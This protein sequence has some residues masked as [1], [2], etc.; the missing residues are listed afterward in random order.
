[1]D[2]LV[3]CDPCID[4]EDPT[5]CTV[6]EVDNVAPGHIVLQLNCRDSTGTGGTIYQVETFSDIPARTTLMGGE[7]VWFRYF[8]WTGDGP[9]IPHFFSIKTEA[10]KLLM[11]GIDAFSARPRA[12]PGDW[13]DPIYIEVIDGLCPTEPFDC[14]DLER[15]SLQVTYGDYVKYV[16]D[17]TTETIGYTEPYHIQVDNAELLK[18]ISC[19]GTPA[20]RFMFIVMRV[21][22]I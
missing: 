15:L 2:F 14:Y 16:M 22:E 4:T 8:Q 7:R 11:A 19:G 6:A 17:S 5:D 13:Y 20:G 12:E 21:P 3:D 9:W 10:G 1:V 18:N